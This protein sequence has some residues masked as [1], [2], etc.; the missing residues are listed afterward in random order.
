MTDG[1]WSEGIMGD[2][3]V[4]LYDGQPVPI[5]DVVA[6]LNKGAGFSYVN[7]TSPGAE[8]WLN[9]FW[10]D[11][12]IGWVNNVHIAAQIRACIPER[13]LDHD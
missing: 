1:R 11:Y 2:G 3:A 6:A 5:E 9:L 7:V 8:G 4:I 12:P 10:D 13:A